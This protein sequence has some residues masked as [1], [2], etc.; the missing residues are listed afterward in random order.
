MENKIVMHCNE[1]I[2]AMLI[3]Y[4]FTQ[5]ESKSKSSQNII[6]EFFNNMNEVERNKLL[7]IYKGL[8]DEQKKRPGSYC[9]I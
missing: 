2:L 5:S 1:K 9:S 6:K 4:A 8:T 3:A 7:E